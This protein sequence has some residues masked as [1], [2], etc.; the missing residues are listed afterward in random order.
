MKNESLEALYEQYAG[1]LYRYAF[2]LCRNRIQAQELV[3]DTFFQA[4][5]SLKEEHEGLKWWLFRVCKNLWLDGLRR[6]KHVGEQ[7]PDWDALPAE[8]N[9]T[10]GVIAREEQQRVYRA[11][12]ALSPPAY[13]QVVSLFYYGGLSLKEVAEVMDT[14]PGAARTLLCRA[15]QKLKIALEG[16][17]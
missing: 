17:L 15:R 6:Q 9:L 7:P 2:A 8:G 4:L 3:S 14:T 12:L 10:Q 5:L 11:V 13:R 16:Q 1:E